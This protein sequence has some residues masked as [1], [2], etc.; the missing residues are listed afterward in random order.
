MPQPDKEHAS[1]LYRDDSVYTAAYGASDGLLADHVIAGRSI[2]PGASMVDLALAAA[3]ARQRPC[4]ALKDVLIC[5]PGVAREQLKVEVRWGSSS[6]TIHERRNLLCIGRLEERESAPKANILMFDVAARGEPVDPRTVYADLD[7]LG[8][9][10][11]PGLQVIRSVLKLADGMLF[12]LSAGNHRDCRSETMN[13]ALL[14]GAIQAVFCLLQHS[15]KPIRPGGLLVPTGIRRL[16]IHGSVQG[17][18][19]VQLGESAVTRQADD[20]LADLQIRNERGRPL[21]RIEGLLLKYVP[22]DFLDKFDA[23]APAE[24]S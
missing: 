24:A 11:G 16:S 20:V 22:R 19:F 21:L 14:D 1:A 12:G 4:L 10:Y 8:Y 17:T 9:R 2:L 7:R 3:Q 23:P 15:D 5:R 18:C 13:P 6:F